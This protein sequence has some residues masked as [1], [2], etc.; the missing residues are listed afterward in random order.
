MRFNVFMTD[1]QRML[2]LRKTL[3]W[4]QVRLAQALQTSQRTI[5]GVEAGQRKRRN[6]PLL[7][8]LDLLEADM[9]AGRI[10][11]GQ[12]APAASLSTNNLS[13]QPFDP[14]S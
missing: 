5:W 10:P 8:L 4:S 1:A 3:G 9:A 13:P 2:K 14:M 12:E 6:G 11:L 7:A